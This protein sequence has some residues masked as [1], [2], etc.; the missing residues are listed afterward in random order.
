[1]PHLTKAPLAADPLRKYPPTQSTPAAVAPVV[2]V[3]G[4][5]PAAGPSLVV[6]THALS[7]R[8][9]WAWAVVAAYKPVENRSWRPAAFHVGKTIAIHASVSTSD[10]VQEIDDFLCHMHP[11]I[12]AEMWGPISKDSAIGMIQFGCLIGTVQIAGCE[13]FDESDPA[14]SRRRID[15]AA[16]A[17][18]CHLVVPASRWA[19]PGLECWL[20]RQ[21]V[22]FRE[23]IPCPGKLNL[24]V[25]TAEMR[26]RIAVELRNPLPSPPNG[27]EAREGKPL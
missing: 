16:K 1:M 19:N 15:A 20:V 7:I 12:K 25:L 27:Q 8:Q 17:L 14:G 26:A 5:S 4:A 3:P 6:P 10:M 9:P 2:V 11:A 13:R 23:T 22:Q 18:G 24:W 21:A